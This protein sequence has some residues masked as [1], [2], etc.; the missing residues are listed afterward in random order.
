M[1][2]DTHNPDNTPDDNGWDGEYPTCDD[3][4]GKS[5]VN[6]CENRNIGDLD[7]QASC[8]ECETPCR[9]CP[10]ISQED[11]E[12]LD[13]IFGDMTDEEIAEWAAK[14]IGDEDIPF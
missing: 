2:Y 13:T 3:C 4:P 5:S 1:T 8:D 12:L 14:E 6:C 9:D 7:P 10:K 11:Q